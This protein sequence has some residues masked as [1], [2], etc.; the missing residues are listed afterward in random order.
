[1]N[2]PTPAASLDYVGSE[3]ELFAKAKNWKRYV[4]GQVIPYLG[5]RVLEVGAGLG[6]T[7]RNLCDGDQTEWRLLEPDAEMCGHMRQQIQEQT[8]PA[9]CVVQQGIL[10]DMAADEKFDSILY[11]DVLEH[12]EHDAAEVELAARHLQPGGHLVVLC[13]AHQFL[14]T[15]FDKSIGHFRRY[16]KQMM[17]QLTIPA[18]Q[19]QRI[20][21]LDSVGLTASLANKLLLK[22]SLPTPRQ[23]AVWD[24]LM[25]P[26]SRVM[27]VVTFR[28]MGKSILGIWQR[29]DDQATA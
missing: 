15:A 28:T 25:V 24:R 1:M 12:I 20:R 13:P 19:V 22:Q 29:G 10:A 3:L 16:N 26:V 23:I 2:L 5:K 6:E 14:Y 11:M 17:K 18:L 8:L 27:D 9:C 7:S 21:Y 4:R